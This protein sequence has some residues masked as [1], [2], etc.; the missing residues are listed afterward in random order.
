[1]KQKDPVTKNQRYLAVFLALT[2]LLSAGAI[3]FSGN[4]NKDKSDNAS[5][6]GNLEENNTIAFSQIPG[7]QVH[8]EFNSIADGL[9]MSPEGVV[10]ASYVDLQRTT[11]TPFEQFFGNQTI[12]YSLYGADVTKRYGARYADGNGFELHQIPERKMIMPWGAVQYD[13]YSLLA[14]TNNTYDIWNVAGS[15]V[16]LGSRQSVQD[17]IDVL[18]GNATASTE[19]NSLLSQANTE[20]SLYQELTVKTNNSTLPADQRYM[21]IKKLDDG[22]YSQTF[23]YLNP[24]SNFTDEIKALQANSTERGVTYNVTTSGN[25]TKMMITSDFRSLLNETEMLSQ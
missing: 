17:V 15:P 2:M 3:F 22:S 10:S 6:S 9:N 24:E 18:Q 1:M 7:R 12:M 25:I 21:D 23:L 13:N 20:G 16:I 11:G 5:S 19:Y 8:H 14:R 4:S